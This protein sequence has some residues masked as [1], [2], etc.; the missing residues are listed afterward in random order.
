M[1]GKREITDIVRNLHIICEGCEG[2]YM[3]CLDQEKVF[4]RVNHEYLLMLLEEIGIKGRLLRLVK[5]MYKE[6][7]CQILVQ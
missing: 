3:V 6:I 2:D 7:M 5:E 4:D 1:W